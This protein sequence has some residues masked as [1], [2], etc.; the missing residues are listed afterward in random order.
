MAFE[1]LA[2]LVVVRPLNPDVDWPGP[3][4]DP[5]QPSR[6]EADWSN[7]VELLTREIDHLRAGNERS[8]L[9]LGVTENQ[10]RNDGLPRSGTRITFPGVILRIPSEY[11]ELTYPCD[12]FVTGRFG[13]RGD[14]WQ[15]N[16]RAVALGLEALRKVDR[17]GIAQ[18][19]QQ[20]AGWAQLPGPG[21]STAADPITLLAS[22]AEADEEAWRDLIATSPDAAKRLVREAMRNAH[23]D[24]GGTSSG[25]IAVRAAAERLQA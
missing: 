5:R 6:F 24:H 13:D 8:L 22:Y 23:P 14:A 11:G 12:T 17:Y 1:A 18:R 3:Q 21:E 7:T 2:D 16:L 15:H 10:L 25:F 4:T 20:Y 19:G 9:Q